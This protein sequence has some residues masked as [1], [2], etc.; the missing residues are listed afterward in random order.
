MSPWHKGK[1]NL[2]FPE[3]LLPT[4]AMMPSGTQEKVTAEKKG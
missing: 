1:N 2:G 3:A 4:S